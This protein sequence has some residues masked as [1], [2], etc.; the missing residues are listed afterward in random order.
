MLASRLNVENHVPGRMAIGRLAGDARDDGIASL[1]E[2][3]LFGK[4]LDLGIDALRAVFRRRSGAGGIGPVV[5][6]DL[7]G[8]VARIGK[9]WRLAVH[10]TADV[11]AMHMGDHDDGDLIRCV[12]GRFHI[13]FQLTETIFAAA[14]AK[15]GIEQDQFRSGIDQNG[16]KAVDGFRFRQ[17]VCLHQFGDGFRLLIGAKGW[18]RTIAGPQSIE[19]CGDLEIT[20]L[21][22]FETRSLGV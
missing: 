1:D 6:F 22:T 16:S 11:I 14:C 7:T 21:E 2:R 9:T 15:P 18:M 10:Q 5:I 19:Q 17:K 8:D 12:S 20:Q 4:R 13:G 3:R